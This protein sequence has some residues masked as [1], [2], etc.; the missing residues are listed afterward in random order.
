MSIPGRRSGSI[1]FDVGV[2]EEHKI[3]IEAMAPEEREQL[4]TLLLQA[5]RK[6]R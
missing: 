2:K 4:R 3:D 1:A 6:V 5:T